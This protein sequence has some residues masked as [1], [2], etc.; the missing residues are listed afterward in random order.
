[1]N[2]ELLKLNWSNRGFMLFSADRKYRCSL[3][4]PAYE[5]P[6]ELVKNQTDIKYIILKSSYY[7][8]NINDLLYYYPEYAPIRKQVNDDINNLIENLYNLYKNTYCYKKNSAD[9]IPSKYKKILSDIQKVYIKTHRNNILFK[10]DAGDVKTVL[11]NKDCPYVF[12][13]LYK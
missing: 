5:I 3:I 2:K 6:L 8:N 9:E 10:I 12:T 11:I 7:T 13:L 1:M 4:N